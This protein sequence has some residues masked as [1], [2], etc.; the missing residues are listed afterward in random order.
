MQF[1]NNQNK[2]VTMSSNNYNN[3]NY[4][5]FYHM[6]GKVLNNFINEQHSVQLGFFLDD[7]AYNTNPNDDVTLLPYTPSGRVTSDSTDILTQDSDNKKYIELT[8]MP[9]SQEQIISPVNGNTLTK[10][11]DNVARLFTL[12]TDSTKT[13]PKPN[14]KTI[15]DPFTFSHNN[16]IV[17]APNTEE[18]RNGNNMNNTLPNSNTP[19]LK[20]GSKIDLSTAEV[21]PVTERTTGDKINSPPEA[22]TNKTLPL[23]RHTPITD[24]N[25]VFGT[26]GRMY[27][28][29]M[30]ANAFMAAKL[31]D[32]N[33]RNRDT[34]PHSETT[35][36]PAKYFSTMN[37]RPLKPH[38]KLTKK[39]KLIWLPTI[40]C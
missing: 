9:S 22:S 38:I 5:N 4:P 29:F 12:P 14:N 31:N 26:Y 39:S 28:G 16:D 19:A 10:T 3:N 24:P 11:N 15:V 18:V 23:T 32:K 17:Q 30:T 27:N 2:Q 20:P 21:T 36:V 35:Q 8:D 34:V 1:I 25:A 40:K 13:F 7:K 33:N 37:K 6:Q